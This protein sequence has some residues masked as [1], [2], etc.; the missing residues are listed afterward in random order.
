M[1]SIYGR[2][3]KL[4]FLRIGT[5][6]AIIGVL[7]IIAGVV[8]FFIDRASHQVPL[9]IE[10][11]PGAQRIQGE[12]PRATN[13]RSIYYQV[14]NATADDVASYY[15]QELDQFLGNNSNDQ[16]REQCQRNPRIGNFPD[17]D[18]G[19]STEDEPIAPYQF[20]CVFDRSGFYISQ[21]TTI[22]IQPGIPEAN[23]EGM[24]IIEYEQHW[25]S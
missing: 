18:A 22:I 17:Y 20:I 11:Y 7:V 16:N 24:V 15:Q 1:F 12:V 3:G 13:V 19:L 5:L 9:D 8:L 23:T 2:D 14:P 21:Y 6:G 10:P 4:S 25:Q